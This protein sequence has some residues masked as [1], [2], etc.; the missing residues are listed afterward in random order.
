MKDNR[1]SCGARVTKESKVCYWCEEDL[2]F[3]GKIRPVIAVSLFVTISFLWFYL[4]HKWSLSLLF[5]K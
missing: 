1:C 5:L 4:I 3:M 2:T